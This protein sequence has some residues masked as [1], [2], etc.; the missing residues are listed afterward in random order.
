MVFQSV[1][2]RTEISVGR[3]SCV[4]LMGG[5]G[6]PWWFHPQLPL[7]LILELSAWSILIE[8]IKYWVLV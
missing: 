1:G 8:G 4:L 5:P 6:V 7:S 3:P 2:A